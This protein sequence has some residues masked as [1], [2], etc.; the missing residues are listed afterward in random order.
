ML[1]SNGSLNSEEF[2]DNIRARLKGVL[3]DEHPK[4]VEEFITKFI[5]TVECELLNGNTVT[6]RGFGTFFS[7]TGKDGLKTFSFKPSQTD[8]VIKIDS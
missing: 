4:L 7:K 3:D 2:A 1:V 5:E 6:F 8:C